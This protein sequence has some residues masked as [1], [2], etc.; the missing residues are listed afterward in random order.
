MGIAVKIWALVVLE[1]C[2]S[3][4]LPLMKFFPLSIFTALLYPCY[5]INY[6]VNTA[7]IIKNLQA[8]HYIGK[9]W[10]GLSSSAQEWIQM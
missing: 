6:F 10:C 8:S 5:Y 9:N 1:M 7:V 3:T 4:Q 2:N